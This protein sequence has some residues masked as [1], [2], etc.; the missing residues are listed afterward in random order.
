MVMDPTA[1]IPRRRR[2]LVPRWLLPAAGVILGVLAVA[3]VL[4]LARPGVETAQIPS[5]D[6]LDVSVARSRLAQAGFLLEVGDRRFSDASP[7]GTVLE[8]SPAPGTVAEVRSVVTVVV[9]AGS[10]RFSM[11]DVIGM[12]VGQARELL[13]GKGLAVEVDEVGSGEATGVVLAS[14][15]AP[16]VPVFNS[17]VVRLTVA[18]DD[19]GPSVLTRYALTGL[20]FVIDP[21]PVPRPSSESTAPPDVTLEVARRLRSLLEASG[22][23]VS[24]TRSAVDTP[25]AGVD[26]VRSRRASEASCTA[27]VG[28]SVSA[29]T[30][31]VA[32]ASLAPRADD[33][34]L[35]IP[36]AELS[37][38]L[39]ESLNMSG[40][41]AIAVTV[42]QD[43]VLSAVSVPGVRVRLGSS[44]SPADRA[45]FRDPVW[46]DG[47]AR[48]I[49]RA[50]GERFGR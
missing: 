26:A 23:G 40:G 4:L 47:T 25:G 9:S 31:G 37:R 20:C 17:G 15:P 18:V 24:V 21:E 3:A 43:P 50:L 8:Q 36:S 27:A 14:V 33:P 19:L 5:I 42:Q 2:S 38:A 49:Y 46:A 16:G 48:A 45:S 7:A 28:L 22:A 13:V 6:S 11:P 29:S 41:T 32:V 1:H 30:P 10:E 44:G 39:L 34:R 12:P 35:Y